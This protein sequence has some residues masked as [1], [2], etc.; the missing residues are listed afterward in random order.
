[1]NSAHGRNWADGQADLR[2]VRGLTV[3]ATN[4]N[5]DLYGAS[6][7][8]LESIE[9]MLASGWRVVVS[10]PQPS[11]P[12]LHEIEARGGELRPVPSPVLRK[13]Y[14]NVRGLLRLLG[15]AL[16]ALPAEIRLLRDVRPDVI[17]VNT[18]IQPLWLVLG[19]CL[20][21]PVVCHVHEG[22]ASTPRIVR[23]ALSIPLAL[24]QRVIVNSHFSL[25]VLT[26]AMPHAAQRCAVVLNGIAGPPRVE[27][28]RALLEEPLRLC[29]TGRLSERKGPGDAIEAVRLLALRGVDARLDIVG[30]V[31]PGMEPVEESLRRQVADAGL[32]ERVRFLGFVPSVW[33]YLAAADAALVP[34]RTDESFGNTAV[35]A[36]LAARPVIATRISGLVEATA[37]FDGAL[38]V[39]PSAPGDIA[40]AVQQVVAHWAEFRAHAMADAPRAAHRH[41]P[42]AY[43]AA[44]ARVVAACVAG[45]PIRALCHASSQAT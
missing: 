45:G 14:L 28:P 11:G 36:I 15:L 33:P 3:L 25:R 19:R 31:F 16:R 13:T 6:R 21:I 38:L 37:G 12:L 8:F 35:E 44:V 17:Y 20:G 43:H 29:Y 40:D 18:I 9:G 4:P 24:A 27:A 5:A 1:M 41:A 22:E 39:A 7:M 2:K 42:A 34:S 10:I 23:K 26:D 30:A 32:D